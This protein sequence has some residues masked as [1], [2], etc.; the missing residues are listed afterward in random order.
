MIWFLFL[1]MSICFSIK[2]IMNKGN[3]KNLPP[4]PPARPIIDR[5]RWITKSIDQL[6]MTVSSLRPKLGPIVT[7]Y[8]GPYTAIFIS[9]GKLAHQALIQNGAALADRPKW[10]SSRKMELINISTGSYGLTWRLLRRNLTEFLHPSHN[11]HAKY[12][13]SHARKRVL[14][15]LLDRL[16]SDAGLGAVKVMDHLHFSVFFLLAH[17]C[18]GDGLNENQVEQ[19]KA[20]HSSVLQSFTKTQILHLWPA[21]TKI[22]LR[23]WWKE[24][25]KMREDRARVT[26]PLIRA[27]KQKTIIKRINIQR[28][29][30]VLKEEKDDQHSEIIPCYVDTLLDM[31]LLQEDGERRKLAEEEMVHLCSEFMNAGTDTTA[32]S[33]EW[34][35]ANIVKYPKIQAKLYQEIK[36]VIGAEAEEVREE[37]LAKV[38]YLRALIL[39]GLR[40]H[41]PGHY[42]IPH[43]A[44]EETELGGYVAPKNAVVNFMVAQIGWDHEVWEEPMEF[45]PE[46]FLHGDRGGPEAFD[47]TG[48]REM[49]K[50]IPFGAGRRICPA[51]GLA[52]LHLEYLVANL[53]CKFEWKA[54]EG[55]QVDL[56]EKTGFTVGMKHPLRAEISPREVT[57]T[58]RMKKNNGV[59][60]HHM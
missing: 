5:L 31:E 2:L 45:R 44:T 24:Y 38:P 42:V 46:R 32:T 16:K 8:I 18:F 60:T 10:L 21:L 7:L 59:S 30:Q 6:E 1:L 34:I 48:T 35:M 17:M 12:S 56:A 36:A 27:R 3:K 55:D 37:D 22:L 11:S 49:I 58:H 54:V 14:S 41:P 20:V 29:E 50:M 52:M 13:Y 39:E 43:V 9:S 4:T 28:H 19:I 40:R 53:V 15:I 47:L 26:M 33:L 23:P 25:V 57:V 51:Y